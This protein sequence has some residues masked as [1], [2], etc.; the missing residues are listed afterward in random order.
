MCFVCTSISISNVNLAV[1]KMSDHLFMNLI[2]RRWRDS[3]IDIAP[4]NLFFGGLI[5][6]NEPIL[7]R[8]TCELTSIAHECA[9]VRQVTF[10][11]YNGFFDEFGWSKVPVCFFNFNSGCFEPSLVGF[12]SRF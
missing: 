5:S 3:N 10:T 8:T 1:F 2:E 12:Y 7:R 11:V 4:P 9:C 6:N